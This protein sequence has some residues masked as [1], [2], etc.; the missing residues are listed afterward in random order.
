MSVLV[1][2]GTGFIGS[3]LAFACMDRG[4]QVRVLGLENTEA[5]KVNRRQL[6]ERGAE[7]M[8]GSVG[9]PE[10]V[11]RALD[12]IALV[13]HL[14]AAQH[15]MNVPD[16]HFRSINID[17]TVRLL[18][19]ARSHRVR[20]FIH[21][22]TI[23]VY[24][25]LEGTISEESLCRPDNVYGRT[26]LEGESGVLAEDGL[27]VVVIRIPEVYGPG[28]RRL[29]KLFRAIERGGFFLIG[30]C[31]N[32]HH[33][34][35][36]DDLISGLLAASSSEDVLG[37]VLLLPGREVV[38]T[39]EMVDAV[40]EALGRPVP[41]VRLPL[42]PLAGLAAVMEATLRPL[43][44]QPPL[45]RRRLDFFRKSF[46]LSPE[47]SKRLLGFDAAVG[48]REGAVRTARWYRDAGLM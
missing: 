41:R 15:E 28:D 4:D 26:K 7:V 20:R 23:G 48:F 13:F 25:T 40:A 46:Q 8:L 17:G 10:R 43:G 34:I 21:G 32:A 39:R 37:E 45:H 12:G 19:A 27:P 33:P 47:K 11:D 35:Y 14:A 1:T 3:R 30:P 42:A 22:S 9:D 38:T 5:E 31:D 44:V 29:L 24:G 2:G 18:R 16:E 6:E 36:I